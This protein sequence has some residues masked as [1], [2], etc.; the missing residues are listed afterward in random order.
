[1]LAAVAPGAGLLLRDVV[2]RG[3]GGPGPTDESRRADL[4]IGVKLEAG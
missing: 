4:R 2:R 3:A 1:M